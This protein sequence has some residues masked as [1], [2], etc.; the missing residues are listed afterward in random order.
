[1]RRKS[2]AAIILC[3]EIP[4]LILA[5]AVGIA[6]AAPGDAVTPAGAGVGS[7][8]VFAP[9]ADG[10]S[11]IATPRGMILIPTPATGSLVLP[12]PV[13]PVSGT[14]PSIIRYELVIPGPNPAQNTGV[15]LGLQLA[16]TLGANG[17]VTV[18]P[19]PGP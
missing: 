1:M 7:V 12:I 5:G 13:P 3:V 18:Y 17:A 14:G 10:A 11:S 16:V 8:V 6:R 2:I 19:I 9:V 15:A 4:A